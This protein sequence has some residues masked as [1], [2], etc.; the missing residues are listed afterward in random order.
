[1]SP[2]LPRVTTREIIAVLQRRG[3]R[4][5]RQSGSHQI[6]KDSTGTRVTVPYHSGSTVLHPK[7]LKAILKDLKLTGEELRKEL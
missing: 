2:R 3:F 1:M 6:Y 4:V 5:V 7:L